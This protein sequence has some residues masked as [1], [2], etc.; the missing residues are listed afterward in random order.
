MLPYII[1]PLLLSAVHGLQC[2]LKGKCIN[3]VAVREKRLNDS[4]ECLRFCQGLDK[5]NWY[6][7]D[8]DAEACHAFSNC[9]TLSIC[10]NCLTGE[11][12]CPQES[13][14]F[15]E[16]FCIGEVTSHSQ[17]NHAEKLFT[18]M[19]KNQGVSMV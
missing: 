17:E 1:F 14:C 13:G 18:K 16:G 9:Q 8:E 2:D 3:S 11:G 19:S 15:R 12:N 4:V 6:T 7:F 5:C 10:P